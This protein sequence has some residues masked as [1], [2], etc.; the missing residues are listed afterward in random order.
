MKD[1]VTV[2]VNPITISQRM[3]ISLLINLIRRGVRSERGIGVET[4]QVRGK[5]IDAKEHDVAVYITAE[6]PRSGALMEWRKR[7]R[8]RRR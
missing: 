6:V 5:V 8:R 1:R 3:K 7:R 4:P 2:R